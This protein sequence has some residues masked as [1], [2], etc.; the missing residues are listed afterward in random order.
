M[1]LNVS[2]SAACP[3]KVFDQWQELTG[4]VLLER[5]GVTVQLFDEDDKPV[6]EEAIPGEIR[7]KGE[8]VFQEYWN[9]EAATEDSFK[10]GWFCS[11][12]IA[13]LKQ[14]CEGK[15]SAYKI[16]KQ[17]R[18]LDALPRNAMGKVTKSTLKET[19]EW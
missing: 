9:N 17:L 14:W 1:R 19:I 4:Q 16:P 10:D 3:V 2:G 18:I 8:N 7:M 11:G 15:M 12:D 13:D 6:I 5:Y